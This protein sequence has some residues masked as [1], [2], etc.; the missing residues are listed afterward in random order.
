MLTSPEWLFFSTTVQR[1]LPYTAEFVISATP[2]QSITTSTDVTTTYLNA[3]MTVNGTI[4][5]NI[6]E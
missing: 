4:G 5:D 2:D 1:L 6:F 3:P